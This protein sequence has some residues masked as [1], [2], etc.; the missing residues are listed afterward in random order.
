[1]HNGSLSVDHVFVLV[2][3]EH[4]EQSVATLQRAGLAPSSRRSHGRLGTSNV[5]FCFDNCF[6]EILWIAN[7][8]DAARSPL[9]RQ[10][11]ERSDLRG[12][13]GCP[14]G[15]GFRTTDRADPLPF[16]TWSYQPPGDSGLANDIAIAVSASDPEQPLLFRAQR[17]RRPDAWT[18]GNAGLRQRTGGYSEIVGLRLCIPEGVDRGV[19]LRTLEGLGLFTLGSAASSSPD[20]AVTVSCTDSAE[21]KVLSLSR[22][23][24]MDA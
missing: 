22:L 2:D 19:D 4:A 14:F 12:K 20:I 17:S 21:T 24:W 10:L 9:A 7:R 8:A 3:C 16:E 15:I 5:F 6:L 18:D 11:L 23:D 1:M 13:G